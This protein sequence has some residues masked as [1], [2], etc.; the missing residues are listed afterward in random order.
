MLTVLLYTFLIKNIA[1]K[2][3][4]DAQKTIQN[5]FLFKKCGGNV[6]EIADLPA[7][8]YIILNKNIIISGMVQKF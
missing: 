6:T 3:F 2:A 1:F 8:S 4:L 7:S 5:I